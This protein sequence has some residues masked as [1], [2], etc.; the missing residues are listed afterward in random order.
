MGTFDFMMINVPDLRMC[1]CIRNIIM[2][3]AAISVY[4]NCFKFRHYVMNRGI[5]EMYRNM[6]MKL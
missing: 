2:D 5:D 3:N 6:E 4:Q 1:W